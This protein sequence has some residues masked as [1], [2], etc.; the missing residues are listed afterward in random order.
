LPQPSPRPEARS[1]YAGN[2]GTVYTDAK[3]AELYD[4]PP[5]GGT[6]DIDALFASGAV[7][8][9]AAK[10]KAKATGIFF[11]GSMIPVSEVTDG[12]SN[13][14]L[15]GEKY[16]QA[17]RYVT[18]Q[19]HGD[20]WGMYAGDCIEITRWA[21]TDYPPA[22]DS[23]DESLERSFGSPH[24][25]GLNMCFCDGSVRLILYEIDLTVHERLANRHDGETVTTDF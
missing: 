22:K 1:D 6:A 10:I 21:A 17:D 11:A 7:L 25:S 13:T 15:C 14:Y 9:G 3:D 20:L 12:T 5:T 24:P 19:G 2:G 8:A 16:L 18:G 23:L 4:G